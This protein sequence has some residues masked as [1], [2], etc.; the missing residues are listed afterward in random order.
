MTPLIAPPIMAPC[1]PVLVVMV[2]AGRK[3]RD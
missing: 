3:Y 2:A 1:D